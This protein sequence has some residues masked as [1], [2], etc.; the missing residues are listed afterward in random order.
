MLQL[1]WISFY[2]NS[3][4]TLPVPQPLRNPSPDHRDPSLLTPKRPFFLNSKEALLSQLQRSC[5][6]SSKETLPVPQPLRN[7]SPDCRDPSLL[8]PK[9]LFSLRSKETLLSHLQRDPSLNSKET[10]LSQ[11]QRGPSLPTPKRPFS[12]NS[13]EA[14]LP[15]L[16][17]GPSPPTPKRPFPL[18]LNKIKGCFYL[19]LQDHVSADNL[20]SILSE[21]YS[22]LTTANQLGSVNNSL[23]QWLAKA[24]PS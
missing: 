21:G 12:S 10:L 14:H 18:C 5:S 7:P 24:T 3:S 4:E 15:Q 11:L 17:R 13:K 19:F 2:P 6:S 9:R 22:L 1:L 20:P 16:Q 23:Q 8:T